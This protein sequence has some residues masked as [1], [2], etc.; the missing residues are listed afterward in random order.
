MVFRK[1][2][3]EKIYLNSLKNVNIVIKKI[4]ISFDVS[5]Y[6][7]VV[8]HIISGIYS[9]YK[10]DETRCSISEEFNT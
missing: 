9:F 10:I 3:K 2:Q 1:I 5:V 7:I 8:W 4:H 6:K